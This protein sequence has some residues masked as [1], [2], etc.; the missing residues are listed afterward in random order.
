M[1]RYTAI[2]FLSAFVF[3]M[4][5]SGVGSD[6]ELDSRI[7]A[8]LL[9]FGC[10]FFSSNAIISSFFISYITCVQCLYDDLL[11]RVVSMAWERSMFFGLG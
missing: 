11:L 5:W 2:D 8:H 1:K 6:L 3:F 4:D 7:H 10:Q 9:G